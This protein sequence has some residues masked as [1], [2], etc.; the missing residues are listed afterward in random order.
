MSR[1]LNIPVSYVAEGETLAD[2]LKPLA[3]KRV[4]LVDTAGLP[5]SDP[6]LGLQLDNLAAPGVAAKNY[7]VLPATS[8]A[9]VLKAAWHAYKRCG[10]AGCI[11]TKTDE[12]MSL[13]EVLGMAIGHNLP[14]A[15]TTDGPKIPDDIQAPRNQDLIERAVELQSAQEPADDMMTH[16]HAVSPSA[17]HYVG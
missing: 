9:Q 2:T 6:A 3:H 5:A 10:I 15:Y 17:A 8:Q 7:L 16:M 13:G 12:A 4:V 1:I 14:V 11:I